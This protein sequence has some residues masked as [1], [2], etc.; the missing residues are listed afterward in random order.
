MPALSACKR[1]EVCKACSSLCCVSCSRCVHLTCSCLAFCCSSSR[2]LSACSACNQA[3]L[4]CLPCHGMIQQCHSLQNGQHKCMLKLRRVQC[5]ARL[6]KHLCVSCTDCI[7]ML[8]TLYTAEIQRYATASP[9]PALGY[10]LRRLLSQEAPVMLN[11]MCM[12]CI[13]F[14]LLSQ[15]TA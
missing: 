4:S 6:T 11:Q 7:Y 14:A 2:C 5:Q 10:C 15:R 9:L 13:P 1:C 3:K 12:F 8:A